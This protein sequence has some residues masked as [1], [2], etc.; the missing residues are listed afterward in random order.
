MAGKNVRSAC[1][2]GAGRCGCDPG[3]PGVAAD[4]VAF[5]YP[6]GV[7]RSTW[8]RD[9]DGYLRGRGACRPINRTHCG[10]SGSYANPTRAHRSDGK[11]APDPW[12]AKLAGPGAMMPLREIDLL[13]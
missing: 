3:R 1:A 10:P 7:R 4:R 5:A 6:A 13:G 12:S 8:P 11:A 2:T 9:R